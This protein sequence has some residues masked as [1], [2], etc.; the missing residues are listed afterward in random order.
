[1]YCS[2]L[3]YHRVT[4]IVFAP[5]YKQ[6]HND[7][8]PFGKEVMLTPALRYMENNFF[9][10]LPMIV[11]AT[12]ATTS[13]TARIIAAIGTVGRILAARWYLRL[14]RYLPTE[15]RDDV[16]AT[17]IPLYTGAVVAM[18]TEEALVVGLGSLF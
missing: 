16:L 10:L 9:S 3:S 12:A 18:V 14:Q 2:S 11:H 1:M 8:C 5:D 6:R 4:H 7:Q 13:N 17:V 15:T